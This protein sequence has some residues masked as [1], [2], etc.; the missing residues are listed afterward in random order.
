MTGREAAAEQ[1]VGTPSERV[2]HRSPIFY[3]WWI[4]GSGFAISALLGGLMFHAFGAY[5]VVFER[6]FGWSRTALSAAFSIQMVES[7]LL[8]PVQGWLIDR[9]GPRKVM[10]TGIVIFGLG[11]L[12]LSQIDSL[13]T[14][15]IAF[16][17]M[18]LGASLG[19]FLGIAVAVV[20]WFDRRRALAMAITTM[21]FAAGGFG[22]PAVAHSL[23]SLG[24]SGTAFGSGLLVIAVGVPLA[25]LMRHRPEDYGW[26]PDGDL[27]PASPAPDGDR[28]GGDGTGGGTQVEFTAREAMRTQA[29]WMISIGHAVSLLV[30]GA[31]MVHFVPHLNES[32]GYSLGAAANVMLL[33]T[34]MSIAG[35][36]AGGYLGD[37][38]DMRLILVAAMLGH[39]SSLVV[40]AFA[41]SLATVSAFAVLHGLSFG[42]RGPLTQAIRADYFGR[43]SFGT[44]MG[45]SSM[46][47]LVGMLVGPLVAGASY[48]ITGSYR[49]GFIVLAAMAAAGSFAF[50]LTRRPAPP[51]RGAAP[52]PASDGRTTLPGDCMGRRRRRSGRDYMQADGGDGA[53]ESTRPVAE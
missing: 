50:V 14:F 20:N 23:E 16:V 32:L 41:S 6:E 53:R 3:G 15:Y 44:V 11:F 26:L 7:G 45:F 4:V 1:A 22:Q 52:L 10:T 47:I 17:V 34:V 25:L 43:E 19:A 8:G 28:A 24:S 27:E 37:R 2:R 42:A 38:I 48:D 35:M 31:V 30:V 33:I 39:A 29:F 12:M 9:F 40:L 51:Q 18:A 46:I 5:V 21:G 49:T 13:L 36:L